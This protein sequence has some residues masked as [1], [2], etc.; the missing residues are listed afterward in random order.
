MQW[1]AGQPGVTRIEAETEMENLASQRVLEKCGF[2]ATGN[3]GAEGPRYVLV[4]R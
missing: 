4:C 2:V 1:A 3:I